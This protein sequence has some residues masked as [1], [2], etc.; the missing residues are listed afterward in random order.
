MMALT[1]PMW[2]LLGFAAWTVLL[3][4]ATVGA[5]RWV[6]TRAHANCVPNLPVLGAIV[7]VIWAIGV[8]GPAVNY[9]CTIELIDTARMTAC[10]ICGSR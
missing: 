4:M 3:L 9:L 1:I 7:L 2:M 6:T 10:S 8:V 5:Y